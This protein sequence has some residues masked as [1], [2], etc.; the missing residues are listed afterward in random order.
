MWGRWYL[1]FHVSTWIIPTSLQ[2]VII[3]P[4][5]LLISLIFGE[6]LHFTEMFFW[7]SIYV[8]SILPPCTPQSPKSSEDSI[9]R[10]MDSIGDGLS[11]ATRSTF[12]STTLGDA[13]RGGDRMGLSWCWPERCRKMWTSAGVLMILEVLVKLENCETLSLNWNLSNI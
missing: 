11:F 9:T 5:I 13:A 3:G 12:G 4:G 7:R 10:S 2:D 6:K 1:P 8:V